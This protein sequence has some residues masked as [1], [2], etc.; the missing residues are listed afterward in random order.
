MRNRVSANSANINLT[1][2]RVWMYKSRCKFLA[3]E[4]IV[5]RNVLVTLL[6]LSLCG[7]SS[8]AQTVQDPLAGEQ[9]AAPAAAAP[10]E[11]GGAPA[12]AA[13]AAPD[14]RGTMEVPAAP[15]PTALDD[16]AVK[17]EIEAVKARRKKE[18]AELKTQLEEA[19]QELKDLK[20]RETMVNGEKPKIEQAIVDAKK[21]QDD[22]Y[23]VMTDI[24]VPY[25]AAELAAKETFTRKIISDLQTKYDAEFNRVMALH[26][27][28]TNFV[29]SH[30]MQ[31]SDFADLTITLDSENPSRK[32]K[33]DGLA[34]NR[35]EGWFLT[36]DFERGREVWHQIPAGAT[37]QV[38]MQKRNPFVADVLVHF[39][40][41]LLA[42]GSTNMLDWDVHVFVA[43]DFEKKESDKGRFFFV[44]VSWPVDLGRP[45]CWQKGIPPVYDVTP[46]PVRA[47]AD[48][49]VP[50][51]SKQIA[52][53][54]FD[55]PG[56]LTKRKDANVAYLAAKQSYD[57]EVILKDTRFARVERKLG[58]VQDKQK[59]ADQKIN[60]IKL[61]LE[62]YKEDEA[63]PEAPPATQ[64][65]GSAPAAGAA[66]NATQEGL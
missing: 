39:G 11:R 10:G 25:K 12:A 2:I 49:T 19:E 5:M 62:E 46:K 43:K 15:P 27:F 13:P 65:D 34:G 24:E 16:N 7:I 61:K 9:P 64:P 22:A 41:D 8:F 48:D 66:T 51:I 4:G 42:C 21:K 14:A 18:E 37:F 26:V 63:V 36:M 32:I 57:R 31:V 23:Q 58:E 40:A 55:D 28:D 38:S 30:R 17:A 6:T 47:I 33:F 50:D 45:V 56:W 52:E 20:A 59:D 1:T 35:V 3:G 54:K 53:W 44:G 29:A 60:D